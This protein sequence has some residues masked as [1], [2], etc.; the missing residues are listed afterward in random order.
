MPG[1]RPT[2]YRQEYAEIARHACM[3]GATN[4][5][6]AERLEVSVRT[7]GSWIAT[8][9]EF[10]EAVKKGRH[11]A[12]EAVVCALFAR[13]TGM[14]HR[15]TKMFFHDGQPVPASYTVQ[16]PPDV[17]ACIFWL[18]N[19]RPQEWRE[20]RPIVDEAAEAERWRDLEEACA[21]AGLPPTRERTDAD[22]EETTAADAAAASAAARLNVHL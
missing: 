12:D 9:P 18:R 8:I 14:E 15:T 22:E 5:A 7:I 20:N 6:L 13:A 4:D 3:L 2:V 17:R 19:R 16:L 21:R 11:V 1:G 10:S